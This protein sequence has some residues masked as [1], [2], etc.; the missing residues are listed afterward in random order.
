M[1]HMRLHLR[2]MQRHCTIPNDSVHIIFLEVLSQ[3]IPCT[4]ARRLQ[5]G[6]G[7]FAY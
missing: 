7:Y 4:M 3:V 6:W 1:L 5:K 2:L